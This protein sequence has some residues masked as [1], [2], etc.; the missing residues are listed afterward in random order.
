MFWE[1]LNQL[2]ILAQ[3]P[4]ESCW[5]GIYLCHVLR[6]TEPAPVSCPGTRWVSLMRHI[7]MPCS[8]R[9]W[10]NSSFLPWHQVSLVDEAYIYAIFWEE[11][12]LLQFLAL[13]PGKS[14]W[15]GINL[16]HVMRW[17]EPAPVS[18]PGTRW[19]SL[20]RHISMP[21]SERNWTC[22]SFMLWHQVSLVDEA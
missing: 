14:R 16:C 7:S 8:E 3:A 20:M 22:S 2:Q 10:T 5:W 1:E 12:N 13:A 11:L 9:N 4:G 6:G 18:C 21:C 15:W 19:V 17:T